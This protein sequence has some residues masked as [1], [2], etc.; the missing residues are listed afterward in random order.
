MFNRLNIAAQTRLIVALAALS[1][2]VVIAVGTY[3]FSLYEEFR[4]DLSDV[5][6]PLLT[7]LTNAEQ[8]LAGVQHD[9]LLLID[10]AGN[11]AIDEPTVYREGKRILD[12][13]DAAADGLPTAV[14]DI[15]EP[16]RR[17]DASQ[18]S[19]ASFRASLVQAVEMLSVDVNLSGQYARRVTRNVLAVNA[20]AA[21]LREQIN[22]HLIQDA[23]DLKAK[24]LTIALPVLVLS[25][26]VT[27]VLFYLAQQLAR[28][29]GL[30]FSSIQNTLASLRKGETA[31][32]ILPAATT[33]EASDI[34]TSLD[35]FRRTMIE[36]TDLRAEL[37]KTVEDRTE[38]LKLANQQLSER[39]AR[40]YEMQD[41]LRLF[42][43]I[44]ESTSEAIIITSLDG[45][46]LQVNN[47]YVSITGFAREEVVG[48]NPR[49]AQ[50]GR[51]DAEFYRTMW[52]EIRAESRWI[53]EI[54]DKR[55]NGEIYPKLLSINTVFDEIGEPSHYVGVFTDISNI[56][57][58]ESELERMA[59]FDRLTGL[60]NRR[61]LL[62]R[63][64]HALSIA[65]RNGGR[66][67]LFF[68]DI[69][70]FKNIN[71]TLGHQTG[72]DL[73]VE[74]S[75]R[76][77]AAVRESDTVGRLAGD[78]FLVIAEMLSEDTDQAAWQA[79]RIGENIIEA[80]SVPYTLGE[81]TVHTSSS[82]GIT[83]FGGQPEGDLDTVISEAD[84]AM[85]EAKK[86]G[87]GT[88]C[89][90]DPT[91][92]NRLRAR[93]ELEQM[94]RCGLREHA[95]VLHLQPQFDAHARIIG[96]EA[97][98]RL[99]IS[100]RT[101]PP[102]EF[103]PVAEETH[104]IH[105][106][107]AW[108]LDETCRLL[109]RW[110]TD[111]L[112]ATLPIAINVSGQHF[113]NHQFVA[114]TREILLAHG[115]PAARLKVELTE[116]VVVENIDESIAKMRELQAIGITLA[117]DDFGTGYSSLS[118]LRRLPFDQIKIDRAFVASMLEN[119]N[120]AFIIHTVMTMAHLLKAEVVAE[121]VETQEQFDALCALGCQ[122]FQGYLFSQPLPVGEFEALVRD[123]AAEDVLPG[124]RA[125]KTAH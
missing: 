28:Q 5:E 71:D 10:N 29:I 36:L 119:A 69:D 105:E 57:A 121:G 117:M 113:A 27:L 7:R 72:D 59:F 30:T 41:E 93:V 31:A 46:I 55:R 13:F 77:K 12:R 73:L 60:P 124:D 85:Y 22:N 14:F 20:N 47:A 99:V 52:R 122:R 34:A 75:R 86:N 8:A 62:D 25:L 44:F 112:F 23:L 35:A 53:G 97:L 101:I 83:L 114:E 89:F 90:F 61:L 63:V 65:Q 3:V 42:K 26:F 37:E 68:L 74:V 107:G 100:G 88:L 111:S 108:V 94:L 91:M 4:R 76:L 98:I 51:H 17:A 54:W 58:I 21:A 110:E 64:K 48:Q 102:A 125:F 106:I 80:L 118:Y 66:S 1:S 78:E 82:I 56:K 92:Q 40:L 120:D 84:T 81:R 67:A 43:R 123:K 70:K 87:R 11:H 16:N 49:I 38:K 6:T 96:A 9:L 79:R 50:S 15:D 18:D 95:F 39:I 33:P 19:R 24:L 104:L 109:K 116:S 2:V 115:V 32:E 103:I 45:T